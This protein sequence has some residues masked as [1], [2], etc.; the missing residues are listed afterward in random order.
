MKP[1]LDALQFVVLNENTRNAVGAFMVPGDAV[2]FL[3]VLLQKDHA[4]NPYDIVSADGFPLSH[5]LQ[6]R[7]AALQATARAPQPAP[8][9]VAVGLYTFF[10]V[11]AVADRDAVTLSTVYVAAASPEEAI[12]IQRRRSP[13]DR[14]WLSNIAPQEMVTCR[15]GN[16]PTEMTL[17]ALDAW[18]AYVTTPQHAD[19]A[20]LPAAATEIAL[21]A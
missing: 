21:R 20:T 18:I 11:L 16:A 7:V 8:A 9:P 3:G 12:A 4:R 19:G 14:M 6:A 13:A 5:A 1:Q 2:S 15:A 10:E 17:V